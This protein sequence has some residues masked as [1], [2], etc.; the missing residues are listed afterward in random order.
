MRK[1]KKIISKSLYLEL[2]L[3][4]VVSLVIGGITFFLLQHANDL[5]YFSKW[6]DDVYIPSKLEASI[7]DF[8]EYIDEN[9]LSSEDKSMIY[10]WSQSHP[11][12]YFYLERDGVIIYNF[13]VDYSYDSATEISEADAELI[14]ESYEYN[15]Y[16]Y[17]YT[18]TLIDGD[19]QMHVFEDF[20]Y[21]LYSK[22]QLANIVLSALLI[23]IL[24]TILVRKKIKYINEVTSGIEILAGGDLSYRIPVRGNDEISNVADNINSMSIAV[25][26]QIENEKKAIQANNSLVTALSHDL[27]TPLTTQMGYLEI[28]KEHHYH[29]GEEMDKYVN[30]A[31]DTCF[32]IKEMSDRLFEYFLAFDPHPERSKETLSCYDGIDFLMQIISE[33]SLP[34]IEQ[35][36][37]FEYG[38]PT[39]AFKINVNT[40]D[41]L[42]VFNN[43]FTNID[44][45]ADETEP[46]HVG[47]K[48]DKE[49]ATLSISNKIRSV[50]RK[51]ESAKI[52]LISIN[53]LMKRQGGSSVT[54]TTLDTFTIELKFPIYQHA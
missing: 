52:G 29:S 23:I 9:Q 37:T 14:E 42:R 16:V 15:P 39:E 44:K 30:T 43:V 24:I 5:I 25:A 21:D 36:F 13:Y 3:S 19:C 40:D 27:R 41:I 28:L 6:A 49:F 31:L 54:K 10:K 1:F 47:L 4:I 32:Q 50:P 17:D 2:W 7:A 46:V 48:C 18:I 45:Y 22:I 51:N 33:L 8:Q 20:K 35:G 11:L 34:L 53:S 38:E 12:M 26:N